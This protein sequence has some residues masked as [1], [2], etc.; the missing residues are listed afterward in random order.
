MQTSICTVTVSIQLHQ[1]LFFFVILPCYKCPIGTFYKCYKCY[2]KIV[3]SGQG[4]VDAKVTYIL[5][6]Y[7][8]LPFS[9]KDKAHNICAT[10][11]RGNHKHETL[12]F[13][14]LLWNI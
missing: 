12:L 2:K 9:V 6:F 10:H 14:V 3:G 13:A 11:Y 7:F 1:Q 5:I 8:N 4:T